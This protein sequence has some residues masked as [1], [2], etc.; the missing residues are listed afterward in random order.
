MLANV[1]RIVLVLFLVAGVPALSGQTAR[2]ERVRHIPR[3]AL[4]LSAV[5]SQWM[6]AAAGLGVVLLSRG[7]MAA[8]GFR[9]VGLAAFAGWGM[10]LAAVTVAGLGLVIFLENR[11]WWPEEPETVHLLM[12]ETRREKLWAVFAVAPT[13]ALCEEFLYRGFLMATLAGWFNSAGWGLVAA[14]A[15]FGLAHT[16]QGAGGV[17]RA[18]V[19]GALLAA[20]VLRTGSLYPAML[21]HFLI[22]AAALVWL[23][24]RFLKRPAEP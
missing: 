13:A 22:D 3:L 6:L 8:V 2:P 16:Y 15:A 9:L 11:G 21:A 12:P 5:C 7:G 20:S 10:L 19:L 18:G 1:A 14:S 23:G 24:P 4:Y 17:A